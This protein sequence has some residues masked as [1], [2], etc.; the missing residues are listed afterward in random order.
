[1]RLLSASVG[2]SGIRLRFAGGCGA[3]GQQHIIIMAASG[4]SANRTT[5]LF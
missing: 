2:R 5:I 4:Q 1:M 3:V